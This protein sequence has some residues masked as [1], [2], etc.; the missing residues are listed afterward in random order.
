[1]NFLVIY[2][3]Y[4]GSHFHEGEFQPT[5]LTQFSINNISSLHQFEKAIGIGTSSAKLFKPNHHIFRKDRYIT[6]EH[7]RG[8]QMVKRSYRISDVWQETRYDSEDD[9]LLAEIITHIFLA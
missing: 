7:P 6:L 9:P 3:F 5:L 4:Y 2:K 1:M 8:Q